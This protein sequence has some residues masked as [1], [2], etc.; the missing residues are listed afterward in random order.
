[1]T[2]ERD[3]Y[4]DWYIEENKQLESELA[5]NDGSLFIVCVLLSI[6]LPLALIGLAS[7]FGGAP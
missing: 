3:K 4:L 5:R 1:M 2:D 7:V 6:M